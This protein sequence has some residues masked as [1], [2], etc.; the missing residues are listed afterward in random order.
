MVSMQLLSGSWVGVLKKSIIMT[1]NKDKSQIQEFLDSIPDD[2]DI[3]ADGIDVVTQSEYISCSK[4]VG[5]IH[6]QKAIFDK[7]EGLFSEELPVENKKRILVELAHLGTVESY[8]AIEK[9]LKCCDE[10]L[11]GWTLLSLQECRL[12]LEGDLLDDNKGFIS[13]G[14]G[15]KGGKLRYCFVIGQ[16]KLVRLRARL[17][18]QQRIQ[19]LMHLIYLSQVTQGLMWH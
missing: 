3:L 10:E 5:S 4:K 1:E 16:V 15:G 13:T 17:L 2:F 18:K 7:A 6:A 14:L 8:R 12:F 9:F 11:K 19:F